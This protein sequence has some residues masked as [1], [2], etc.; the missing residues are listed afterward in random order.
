MLY[1]E[2]FNQVVALQITGIK[3]ALL[4]I[5]GLLFKVKI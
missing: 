2:E 5:V 3:K 4:K 1:E